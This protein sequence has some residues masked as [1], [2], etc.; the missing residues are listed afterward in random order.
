[1]FLRQLVEREAL[2]Q[3]AKSYEQR[4]NGPQPRKK[5][6]W[7]VGRKWGDYIH[8]WPYRKQGAMERCS[9]H[10]NGET[11]R[12]VWAGVP[13]GTATVENWH[14]LSEQNRHILSNPAIPFL[15]TFQRE[16]SPSVPWKTCVRMFQVVLIAIIKDQNK[17][18]KLETPQMPANR[19]LDE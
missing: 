2:S 10:R 18:N 7:G 14:Y 19:G 6:H 11:C 3:K 4:W 5:L 15:G 16:T 9:H 8:K 12:I 13:I 17:T 1:M